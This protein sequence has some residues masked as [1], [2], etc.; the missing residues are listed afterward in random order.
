MY[1]PYIAY[2]SKEAPGTLVSF[3]QPTVMSL[4]I[5]GGGDQAA[6]TRGVR[7][8]VRTIDRDATSADAFR[9][10]MTHGAVLT[11]IGCLIGLAAA[12]GAAQLARSLLYSVA[13]TD[14]VTFGTVSALLLGVGLVAS[15]IPGRK[16]ASVDPVIALR[17][18]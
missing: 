13:P 3:L 16:A 17:E 15:Y 12:L 5:R 1:Y 11:G 7:E 14:V 4:V 6:V 10:V 8:I 9:L 2:T 18:E